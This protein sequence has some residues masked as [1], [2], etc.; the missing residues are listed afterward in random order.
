MP[1]AVVNICDMI[2][3]EGREVM[4]V[5][6]QELLSFVRQYSPLICMPYGRDVLIE[7]WNIINGFY[8]AMEEPVLDAEKIAGYAKQHS[9]HYIIVRAEQEVQGCFED[10]DYAVVGETDGYV[11]YQDI[12]AYRGY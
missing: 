8:E 4:A 9:C 1:T 11:V 3:V 6:P 7:R 5:F 12:T 2:E 10:Y